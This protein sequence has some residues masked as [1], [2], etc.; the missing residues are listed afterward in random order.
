MTSTGNTLLKECTYLQWSVPGVGKSFRFSMARLAKNVRLKTHLCVAASSHRA[1]RGGIWKM[2][3]SF[4]IMPVL[5]LFAV[6]M[7]SPVSARADSILT[8]AVSI[9]ATVGNLGTVYTSQF[10][11]FNS[12]LGTLVS[13]SVSLSGTLNYTGGGIPADE[14][15][16]LELQPDPPVSKACSAVY[17]SCLFF[18]AL[19]TGLPFSF[20]LSDVTTPVVLSEYTGTG[21][22]DFGVYDFAGNLTDEL[23]MS[24]R[25]DVTFD[26]IPVAVPEP[27]T[28]SLMLIGFGSLGLM[29][30]MRRR[31]AL[32][33]PQA[34]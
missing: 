28:F 23:A 8:E 26:Y 29:L 24:G 21:L 27:S 2:R 34:S 14:G 6:V 10:A 30:V 25:G 17:N 22:K 16:S 5:L 7:L 20:T 31:I 15:A 3:K 33:F 11:A 4:W 19:G 18:P 13:M 1:R 9:S 32:G 12:A